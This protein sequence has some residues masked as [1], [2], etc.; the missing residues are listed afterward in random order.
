MNIR[1][2]RRRQQQLQITLTVAAALLIIFMMIFLQLSSQTV[3]GSK[4][5]DIEYLSVEVL[6]DDTL[7]DLAVEFIDYEYFTIEEYIEEVISING[8]RSET[9]YPGQRLTLPVVQE[10]YKTAGK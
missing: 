2:R 6:T 5:I 9:I 8:L 3:I 1:R 4:D 10:E 7:W